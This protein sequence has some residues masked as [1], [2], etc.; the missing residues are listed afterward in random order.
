MNIRQTISSEFWKQGGNINKLARE[1][2]LNT[3]TV[4]KFLYDDEYSPNLLTLE[5]MCRT[6]GLELV[7]RKVEHE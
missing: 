2:N 7:A 3:K 1:S 4:S 6:L 5:K